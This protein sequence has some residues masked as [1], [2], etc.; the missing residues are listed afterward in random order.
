MKKSGWG[1]LFLL[2]SGLALSQQIVEERF[3]INVEVPVRVFQGSK[4]ID[5]LTM[6]DFELLEDGKPQTLEAV[7]LVK[8]RAIERRD[9]V[10]RFT[11]QTNRSFFLIF[12]VSE[13]TPKMGE[14]L[15]Y[16]LRDVIMPGDSLTIGTPMKSYK[17]KSRAFELRTREEI[18]RQLKGILRRDTV[19]GSMEYRDIIDD[20]EGLAQSITVG[21]S[22]NADPM[23]G[24]VLELENVAVEYEGRTFD[25]QLN[26]YAATLARL[27]SLRTVDQAQM[28]RFA[29]ILKAEAGQKY[30]YM[31]YEREFVPKIQPRL[32]YQYID[33]HQDR[34]DVN[35]TIQGIFEFYKRDVPFDVAKVKRAFADASTAIHFLLITS[36]AKQSS[37]IVYTEQSEDIFS[38]FT[39][40]AEATGGFTQNS[41]N[42]V[43]L[44]TQ[45]VEASET[46]YLLY[47]TPRPYV[48]DGKFHTIAVRLKDKDRRVV[49][50]VG[51]FAD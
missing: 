27:D 35:M 33:I 7:Y 8:R 42:P 15:D 25:E 37:V 14:A 40:M 49:H 4:F 30:V 43:A 20:L 18:A 17:L 29:D 24:R 47:Y 46:Y 45:A 51:Y 22:T 23:A 50:R 6:A 12:E 11:P 16:F 10:K 19:T 36:P 3:V 39:Q 5:T 28:L 13:Y 21:L 44:M 26:L 38:A 31:F 48:K 41:A 9:E 32:L 1:I 2:V 34:P